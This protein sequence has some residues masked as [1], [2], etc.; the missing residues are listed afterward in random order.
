MP[1]SERRD[2][3]VLFADISG[4][5]AMSERL[6]PEAVTDFMNRCFVDLEGVVL[7]NGG[8][9]D[10]FIGDCVLA[11]F[12]HPGM[13]VSASQ[14]AVEMRSAIHALNAEQTLPAPLDV[15][16]GI[17]TGPVIVGEIGGERTR[18]RT[19]SGDTVGLA[20]RLQHEAERGE[21]AACPRT[22]A[23]AA[24]APPPGVSPEMPSLRPGG[25][26]REGGGVP[27]QGGRRGGARGGVHRVA[28]LL[29]RGVAPL[30]HDARQGR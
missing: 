16:I 3:S 29:P 2:V 13:A 17:A 24:Y 26:H 6:D 25:A 7:A 18:A 21:I 8:V 22:R 10:K 15:H 1:S 14:A 12:P 5:T 11:V 28:R 30:L 19:V 20:D 4:F 27:L 23:E 9:V